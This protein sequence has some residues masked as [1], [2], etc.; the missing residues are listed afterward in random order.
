[1]NKFEI[2][3]HTDRWLEALFGHWDG[4][5]AHRDRRGDG[6]QVQLYLS[7]EKLHTMRDR[8]HELAAKERLAVLEINRPGAGGV[9]YRPGKRRT[10]H[11]HNPLIGKLAALMLK[12]TFIIGQTF[13]DV[14]PDRIAKLF[15]AEL[16]NAA[17]K[18]PTLDP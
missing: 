7:D 4:V 11:R 15:R 12:P 14:D 18:K 10:Q 8:M 13:R 3:P 6:V 9:P 2:E 1:M 17:S 5:S 16:L